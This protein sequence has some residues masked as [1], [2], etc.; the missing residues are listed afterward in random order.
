M[1]SS[2][3]T[4]KGAA[5]GYHL[6][7][8]RKPHE[9]PPKRSKTELSKI[10]SGMKRRIKSQFTLE[11]PTI[12]IGKNK[13]SPGLLEEIK[14][15]LDKREVVKIKILKKA[16]ES[17]EAAKIAETISTETGATLIE[18]R[19]HTFVLFKRKQRSIKK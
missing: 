19:G 15:Q 16:I 13:V 6:P 11:K 2:H 9:D 5:R 14:K 18:V 8:M 12:W 10:T 3:K 4:K 7:K 1:S 17:E